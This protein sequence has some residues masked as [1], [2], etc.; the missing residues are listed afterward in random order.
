MIPIILTQI[1]EIMDNRNTSDI[2]AYL[3]FHD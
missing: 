2:K 3:K 1:Y